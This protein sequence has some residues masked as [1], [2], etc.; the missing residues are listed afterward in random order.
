MRLKIGGGATAS[1]KTTYPF[2]PRIALRSKGGFDLG[3][4]KMD[5]TVAWSMLP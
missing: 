3:F 1:T 2:S 4:C 5:I